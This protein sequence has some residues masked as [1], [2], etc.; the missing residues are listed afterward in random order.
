MNSSVND[1]PDPPPACAARR[2]GRVDRILFSEADARG[3]DVAGDGA[4][5]RALHGTLPG[6]APTP[7]REAP[8]LAA[9]LGLARLWVKDEAE[10]LGLRAFRILDA[11]AEVLARSTEG[12]T[13]PAAWERR[14]GRPLPG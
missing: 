12:A 1:A 13:D 11:G 14:V 2:G 4:D 3:V 8:R 5:P 10:R 6:H 9:R 7:L